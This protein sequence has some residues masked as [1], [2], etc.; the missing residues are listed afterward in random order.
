MTRGYRPEEIAQTEATAREQ[1][2]LLEAAKKGPRSQEIAQARAD[3]DAARADEAN[4][5]VSFQRMQTL[6]RERYRIE[7]TV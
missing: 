4:A 2:A 1:A 5:E 7:A 6:V 3:Y